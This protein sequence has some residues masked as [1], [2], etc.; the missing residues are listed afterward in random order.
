MITC[1]EQPSAKHVRCLLKVAKSS[2]HAEYRSCSR[3]KRLSNCCLCVRSQLGVSRTN[4]P[5]PSHTNGRHGVAR[6]D[7]TG[8][9]G[10]GT[11]GDVDA[12]AE[13]V[14]GARSTSRF[15]GAPDDFEG[16]QAKS[17]LA[18]GA[19]TSTPLPLDRTHGPT[20]PYFVP[21]R[22][23][24]HCPRRMMCSPIR[25]VRAT[26]RPAN[27]APTTARHRR[28]SMDPTATLRS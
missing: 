3:H 28:R 2:K 6:R 19:R 9:G 16:G 14:G 8:R 17:A 24:R 21:S 12:E 26:A 22:V 5:P 15:T 4:S 27:N 13:G 11:R 23:R 20:L 7:T 18:L 1:F 25:K 10:Q